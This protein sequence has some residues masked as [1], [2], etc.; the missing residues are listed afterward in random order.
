MSKSE[1]KIVDVTPIEKLD[2]FIGKTFIKIEG[3]VAESEEIIFTL[4][5]GSSYRMFHY[6]DCCESVYLESVVGDVQDL[7]NTPILDATESTNKVEPVDLELESQTWTFYK[8]RTIK[9]YVDLR[10]L[11]QSNGYYSESVEIELITP[12]QLLLH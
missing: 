2:C 3:M 8:F 1:Q 9:G 5:D 12:P 4:S 10:W 6:Q 7:L 11:G